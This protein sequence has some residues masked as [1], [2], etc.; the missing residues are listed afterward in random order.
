[1]RGYSIPKVKVTVNA[2]ADFVFEKDYD[3]KKLEDLQKYI[4]RNKHLPDIPS[5]KEMEAKG[6]E[7]GEMNI[8]LL[9]KIEELTL[10]VIELKQENDEQK[11]QIEQLNDQNAEIKKLVRK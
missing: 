4:Q 1:L 9:Q 6:I 2:G 7:L 8:K 3:L 11:K 10:Y 5:A